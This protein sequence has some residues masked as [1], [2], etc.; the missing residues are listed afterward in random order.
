[1]PRLRNT[2]YRLIK[3]IKQI[4]FTKSSRFKKNLKEKK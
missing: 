2:G 3:N 1:M 4:R